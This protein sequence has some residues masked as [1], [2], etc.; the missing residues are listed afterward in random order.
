MKTD[1]GPGNAGSWRGAG[2][3]PLPGSGAE[4]L[5]G[6]SFADMDAFEAASWLAARCPD[7]PFGYVVTPNADHLVR[8]ARRPELAVLY[9][10]ALLRLLD[11]RVVAGAARLLGLAVPPVATGSEVTAL[12][13]AR[14]LSPGERI[15]ILGLRRDWLPGLVAR[16]GLEAPAH[17]DPP[18]GL[19]GDPVAMRAAVDFVLAHPARFVFLSV[20]SPAQE[21]LAAAI[22][23]TG[24]A[25]GVGLCVGSSLAFLA[26]VVPRAPVWMQRAGLEWLHR[27]ASD[28]RRLARRY[29]WDC[30]AVLPLLVR[31]R[32]VRQGLVGIGGR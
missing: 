21:M 10:D 9:R 4:P 13:L 8:L 30:P 32:L 1:A 2:A 31:E 12:L 7:A 6:L 28:P 11:S 23:T 15:T 20:G 22:R 25:R 16:C 26:G 29:L 24:R 17:F 19:A 3:E 5:L 18:M 27:L 14:H